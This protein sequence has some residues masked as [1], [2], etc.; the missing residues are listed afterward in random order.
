MLD[1]KVLDITELGIIRGLPAAGVVFRD[2]VWLA[3][4]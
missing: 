1:N 4:F 2:V 3:S